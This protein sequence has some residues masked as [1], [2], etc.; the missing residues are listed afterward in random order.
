M[1]DRQQLLDQVFTILSPDDVSMMVPNALKVPACMH[2][3]IA[4][5]CELQVFVGN[6]IWDINSCFSSQL[7]RNLYK[8]SIFQKNN[9]FLL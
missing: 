8:K 5:F 3:R 6:V 9:F 4:S 7:F 2:I 1:S